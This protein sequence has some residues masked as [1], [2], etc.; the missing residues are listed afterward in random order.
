MHKFRCTEDVLNSNNWI[1]GWGEIHEL[2]TMDKDYLQNIL[3]FL[4]K[5]RDKYWLSCKD[6]D[7]IEKIRDGDEFFQVVI[8]NST[9]WKSIINELQKPVEGFNFTFTLPGEAN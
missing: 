9:I 6:V 4:Y 7:L 8:R 2:S 3:Y 1:D 5:K